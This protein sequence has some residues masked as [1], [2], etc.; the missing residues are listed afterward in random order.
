MAQFQAYNKLMI[1]DDGITPLRV[2]DAVLGYEFQIRYPSYRGTFLS[3]IESLHI[4]VDGNPV[5]DENVQFLLNGKTFLLAQL[6]E[7]YKEYW[8]VLD[9]ATIRVVQLGGLP[10]GAHTVTVDMRHRIPYTKYADS[11][12]ALDGHCEKTLTVNG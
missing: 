6:A 3:C 8:Y 4:A 2:D 12:L 11:C 10:A 7:M 9:K 5:P 1:C